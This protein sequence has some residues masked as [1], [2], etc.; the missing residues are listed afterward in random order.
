ML[1]QSGE[2][3]LPLS[4]WAFSYARPEPLTHPE[5]WNL[6]YERDVYRDEYH[7]LLKSRGVDF[8]LSPVYPG[9]AAVFGES[10][11]WNYT[12]IWN[13]L[14]LPS[15]VFP[16]GLTV[17]PKLDA[18]SEQ[19]QNYQPRNAVDRREWK[20]YQGPE[21]Y[22]GAPV[23]LQISGKHFKDEETLAAAKLVE[24]IMKDDSKA[25]KL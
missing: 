24:Q 14:D 19:D 2:P 22:E 16:S 1:N 6:Q 23:A 3:A 25:A 17:D 21:R 15:A 13:V 8:I 20:K 7:A 10:H 9:V 5:A 12:A 18:L 11:Y 4:E